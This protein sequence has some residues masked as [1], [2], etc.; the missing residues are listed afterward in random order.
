VKQSF[1]QTTNLLA[2]QGGVAYSRSLL[3]DGT[4]FKFGESSV[5]TVQNIP[6]TLADLIDRLGVSPK[7]IRPRPPPGTATEHDIIEIEAREDRLCELVDGVLVEKVRGFDE[8]HIACEL[9]RILGNFVKRYD[10][11]ILAGEAGMMRL[12]PGQVRI[13][14]VSFISWDRLP[15]RRRPKATIPELVP[16]LAVEILSEGNTA[17]EMERKLNEY[18]EAGVR[19]VWLIDPKVRQARIYTRPQK[20]RLINEDQSL[21]AGKVLPRFKLTLRKLLGKPE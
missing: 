14:D 15:N 7:R 17:K 2:N 8:S 1:L 18:F 3:Q 11:G 10:L 9:I 16:D 21:E 6:L 13:P 20:H 19:I 12:L 5:S 4:K